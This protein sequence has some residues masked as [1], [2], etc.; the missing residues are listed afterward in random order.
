MTWQSVPSFYHH[1]W[2]AEYHRYTPRCLQAFMLALDI[3][4][5]T[6]DFW[7]LGHMFGAE[8]YTDLTPQAIR[9]GSTSDLC[10]VVKPKKFKTAS[11]Q[12]GVEIR[13]SLTSSTSTL[14]DY[15]STYSFCYHHPMRINSFVLIVLKKLV[16]CFDVIVLLYK[17][18]ATEY[19][20]SLL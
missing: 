16:S 9:Y 6:T 4:Q 14:L 15:F 2:H 11:K 8:C 19:L 3:P 5:E 1:T 18:S 12:G 20:K 13:C 7:Q 10:S 17:N